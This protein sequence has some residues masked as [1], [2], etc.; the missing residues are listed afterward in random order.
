[1]RRNVS[2]NS[3]FE[4]LVGFSRAVRAGDQVFVSGTAPWG[5][6]GKIIEG[7]AYE[8]ARQCI[9]N[10]EAALKQAGASLSDV[11]RTRMYVV[12]MDTW[13]DVS[14]AH[15]EAFSD[16]MPAATLVEVSRL[17]TPEMQVEIKADAVIGT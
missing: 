10:I 9:R 7:D 8:Q 1:M 16:V 2:S 15:R 12:N 11:V 17:A 6:D 14:R 4:P 13:E 3:P 5:P